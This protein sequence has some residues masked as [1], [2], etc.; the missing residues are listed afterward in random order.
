MYYFIQYQI[1]STS[2]FVIDTQY[3]FNQKKK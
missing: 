2:Y 3:F 1:I